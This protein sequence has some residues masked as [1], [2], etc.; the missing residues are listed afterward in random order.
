[1]LSYIHFVAYY[2]K[3][4]KCVDDYFIRKKQL[5]EKQLKSRYKV[6]VRSQEKLKDKKAVYFAGESHDEKWEQVRNVVYERD[7]FKCRLC[8]ILSSDEIFVFSKNCTSFIFSQTLD[9]AHV[10]SKGAFPHLRYEVRNIVIL[11]R[12]SHFNL[13]NQKCPLSGKTISKAEKENW[14]KRIV[15]DE[16]FDLLLS[17]STNKLRLKGEQD[18]SEI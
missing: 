15:G 5:N 16:V 8:S 10:F 2:K 1:M 7:G 14:W 6:Y 4:G 18:G 13:D 12:Y 9:P 3:Q 17:W 11:N